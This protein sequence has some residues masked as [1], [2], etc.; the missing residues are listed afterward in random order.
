MGGV[1]V[2]VVWMAHLR[3]WRASVGGVGAALAAVVC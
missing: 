1:L 2:W 3:G